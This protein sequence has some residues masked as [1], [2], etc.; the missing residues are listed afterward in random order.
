MKPVN[1][2]A[3]K[4][5]DLYHYSNLAVEKAKHT[6]YEQTCGYIPKYKVY[7][8]N[9]LVGIEIEVENMRKGCYPAFYW[10]SKEDNSLR[11]YGLEFTSIPLRMYQVEY[12][13]DHLE[14][15]ILDQGNKPDFSPRTSVH[16]HVNVRD[17]CWEQ[18]KNFI[19]LYAIFERHFFNIAG[20][21]RET[22]VFCVPLY[23]TEALRALQ[24]MEHEE[25]KWHKYSAINPGTILGNDDVP[26]FGTI[27]FRHL[28][29]TLDRGVI[30]NWL[31]NIMCLRQASRLFRFEE[32]LQKVRKL[33]STSEYVA[34]Y[35]A[36]FG[37]YADIYRM[38]KIDFE[39]CV[40]T[41]KLALWGSD[42]KNKYKYKVE[43]AYYTA[44]NKER[45]EMVLKTATL[46]K[47]TAA[48]LT[49]NLPADNE[50]P[51][52]LDT[53]IAGLANTPVVKVNPNF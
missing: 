37:E 18:I 29:G 39:Y 36:I 25:L 43:S 30:I 28:Y 8:E 50:H 20:T 34:L 46:V 24:N 9:A 27:E 44:V 6:K 52:E 12:A 7:D 31:N 10:K 41:T 51:D 16:I 23:K 1:F 14:K 22:S 49:W 47:K 15:C 4:I 38:S 17:M 33:N 2:E 48:D 5:S 26:K 19:L 53:F 45:K 35:S 11:N 32:L 40:S 42:W 3:P 13:L 21:K